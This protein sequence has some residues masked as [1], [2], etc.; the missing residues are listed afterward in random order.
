MPVANFRAVAFDETNQWI[1][2]S[3]GDTF[4]RAFGVYFFKEGEATFAASLF[5]SSWCEFLHN[6][7]VGPDSEAIADELRY[8]G[9]SKYVAFIDPEKATLLIS[10]AY[11]IEYDEDDGEDAAWQAAREYFSGNSPAIEG[12]T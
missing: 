6:E 8:E 7:F 5:P 1:R 11:S 3:G 2:A 4:D 12:I 10:K 9:E